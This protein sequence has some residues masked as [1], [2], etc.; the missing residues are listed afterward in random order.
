MAKKSK[1]NKPRVCL[2]SE[3]PGRWAGD[4]LSITKLGT[5]AHRSRDAAYAM[6]YR[7]HPELRPPGY[8]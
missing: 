3:V 8:D 6:L 1:A 5:S 4:W 2:A 7:V